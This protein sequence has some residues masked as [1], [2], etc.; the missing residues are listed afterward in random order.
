LVSLAKE[1]LWLSS[2]HESLVPTRYVLTLESSSIIPFHTT[3]CLLALRNCNLDGSAKREKWSAWRAKAYG[4]NLSPPPVSLSDPVRK[5]IIERK[6]SNNIQPGQ[7]VIRPVHALVLGPPR[8]PR[9]SLP[10]Y[11]NDTYRP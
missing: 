3:P 5:I 4:R 6:L 2:R 10:N 1:R 7:F 8:G 9:M 11:R